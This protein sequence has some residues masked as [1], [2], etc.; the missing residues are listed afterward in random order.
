MQSRP[1]A[2]FFHSRPAINKT[3]APAFTNI[4]KLSISSFPVN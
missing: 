3:R 1:L 2:G 4:Y